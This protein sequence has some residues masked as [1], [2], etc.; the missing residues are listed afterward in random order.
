MT[1]REFGNLIRLNDPMA[2]DLTVGQV[3]SDVTIAEF[4]GYKAE[5]SKVIRSDVDKVNL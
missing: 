5:S 3:E 4:L 1:K 2:A